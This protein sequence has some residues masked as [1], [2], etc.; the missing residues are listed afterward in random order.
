MHVLH[1]GSFKWL[2]RVLSIV[3]IGIGICIEDFELRVL[4]IFSLIETLQF[5]LITQKYCTCSTYAPVDTY[6]LTCNNK[7]H[8]IF[9]FNLMIVFVYYNYYTNF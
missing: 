3:D 2:L 6:L 5:Q 9:V 7:A 1:G 4:I 8:N